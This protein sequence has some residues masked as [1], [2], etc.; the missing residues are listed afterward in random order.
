MISKYVRTYNLSSEA[1]LSIL[2]HVIGE[3]ENS[4]VN[5]CPEVMSSEDIWD[6][7]QDLQSE[8]QSLVEA[9]EQLSKIVMNPNGAVRIEK[10][11]NKKK[12]KKLKKEIKLLF[13]F[14]LEPKKY[15][16]LKY[17]LLSDSG[18]A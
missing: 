7:F 8:R 11:K 12:G 13:T 2:N 16:L 15:I 6:L 1:L 4:L 18:W 14:L 17:Y 3:D 9:L 10:R 5:S